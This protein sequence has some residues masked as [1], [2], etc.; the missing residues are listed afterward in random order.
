MLAFARVDAFSRCER[1]QPFGDN[2][3]TLGRFVDRLTLDANGAEI[4]FFFTCGFDNKTYSDSSLQPSA[5]KTQKLKL[6]HE[7][8]QLILLHACE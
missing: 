7:A 4:M 8:L 3:N 1:V 2:A 5:S 6:H